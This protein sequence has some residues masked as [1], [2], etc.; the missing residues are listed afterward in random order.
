MIYFDNAATTGKKPENVIK[1][2]ME[3]LQKHS[4]NPGRSGYRESINTAEEIYK[5]REKV[6]SFFNCNEPQNVVFTPNCTQSINYVLKGVLNYGDHVVVSSLEHNAVMRPL[7]KKRNSYT[8]ANVSSDDNVTVEN[9]KKSIKPNTK[10]V[11]CTAA[12]NVNGKILP[13]KKIGRICRE[14]GV[15]FG[16][17]AAQLAGVCKIDV[18]EMNIDFLCVAAHKGFYAP[19]GIGVLICEKNI[20]NTV[21]E[22]GTGTNSLEMSQPLQLPEKLESGTINVPAIF[23]LSAGIDFVNKTG[24][25]KIYNHEMELIQYIYKNLSFN[26]YVILYTP[27]PEKYDFAPVLSFNLKGLKSNETGDFLAKN[28][29]AVRAGYH[30]APMAH[31]QMNTLETGTVRISVSAFN[32]Q[33][34][35]DKFIYILNSQKN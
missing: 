13:L 29:I 15:L 32:S 7:L 20:P 4:I 28:D 1:A 5:V 19:M 10:L 6:A 21:I 26:P 33:K 3:A 34:E 25:E 11:F 8:V 31:K 12:S 23:G 17:D 30:C 27:Y 16:V 9:F 18:K 24:I 35:A 2:V 14:K 22:G